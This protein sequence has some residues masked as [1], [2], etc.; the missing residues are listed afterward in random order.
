M[1]IKF[2]SEHMA[3]CQAA[4]PL[5]SAY[6]GESK[7]AVLCFYKNTLESYHQANL[8]FEF[9]GLSVSNMR[10]AFCR[11]GGVLGLRTYGDVPQENLKSYPVP[12]SNSQK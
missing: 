10:I 2:C 4:L 1:P 12:E 6:K 7:A 3:T 9:V 8:I 5:L 11:R